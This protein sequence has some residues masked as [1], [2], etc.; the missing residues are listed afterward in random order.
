NQSVN[1][2]D[3]SFT[4]QFTELATQELILDQP[5]IEIKKSV[6]TAS[7]GIFTN[8]SSVYGNL[9]SSSAIAS[10]PGFIPINPLNTS[11]F[12]SF[13]PNGI[14]N[15]EDGTLIRYVI[16]VNNSGHGPAFDVQILDNLTDSINYLEISG[17]LP[18]AVDSSGNFTP[19]SITSD[20]L[21]KLFIV[22]FDTPIPPDET[23][24]IIFDTRVVGECTSF[25]NTATLTQYFNVNSSVIDRENFVSALNAESI[26]TS[27][28]NFLRPTLAFSGITV[29]PNSPV[30]TT[31]NNVTLGQTLA[32]GLVLT[33]PSGTFDN[34]TITLQ[35]NQTLSN[36]LPSPPVFLNVIGN[37]EVVTTGPTF[38]SWSYTSLVSTNGSVTFPFSALFSA[39]N[40]ALVNNLLVNFT[41]SFTEADACN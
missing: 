26:V 10:N 32:S 21:N 41:G 15:V 18:Y 9:G 7:Q 25:S 3:N 14:S 34:A 38:F 27:P 4:Q 24:A 31:G 11:Y 1:N 40:P 28:I 12:E 2:F 5:V 22:T 37:N 35:T 13:N 39:L 36:L 20:I 33:L 6:V 23:W 29:T 8:I 16:L 30:I 19:I 17:I